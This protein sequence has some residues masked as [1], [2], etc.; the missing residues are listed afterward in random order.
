M[1]G[2][3]NSGLGRVDWMGLWDARGIL[4]SV[5]A[6]LEVQIASRT[7]QHGPGEDET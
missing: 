4:Q 1:V 2:K 6:D 7:T 3:W 5:R